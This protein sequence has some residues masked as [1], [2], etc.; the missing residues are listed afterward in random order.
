MGYL[1]DFYSAYID[2]ILIFSE[3]KSEHE[4]YVKK[5]LERLWKAGL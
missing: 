2:D 1:D 5:V 4:E 3:D